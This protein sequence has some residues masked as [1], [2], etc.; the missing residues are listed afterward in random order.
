[1]DMSVKLGQVYPSTLPPA[2]VADR[3][4][5]VP[6]KVQEAAATEKNSH[7]RAKTWKRQLTRSGIS[8][9]RASVSWIFPLMI[10]PVGSWS[11]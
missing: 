10:P 11:R 7:T 3:D 1:M 8:S 6:A 2:P 9:S 4:P 5:L